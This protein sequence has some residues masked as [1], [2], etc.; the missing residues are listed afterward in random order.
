[1]G[2][3]KLCSL[4]QDTKKQRGNSVTRG[5]G[6]GGKFGSTKATKSEIRG[7]VRRKESGEYSLDVG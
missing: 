3:E 4:S 2:D 7:P 5:E 1:M 6:L